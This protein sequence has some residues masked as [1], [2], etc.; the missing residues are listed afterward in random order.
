MNK[1]DKPSL[2]DRLDAI[3]AQIER[4]ERLSAIEARVKAL[5]EIFLKKA[6]KK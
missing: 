3:E 1:K 2:E 5:E 6:E 4:L